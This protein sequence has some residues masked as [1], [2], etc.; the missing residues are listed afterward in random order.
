MSTGPAK[1]PL[2]IKNN[3]LQ[4]FQSSKREPN[5]SRFLPKISKSHKTVYLTYQ[6]ICYMDGSKYIKLELLIGW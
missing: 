4:N 3:K 1:T 2:L 6:Q 5:F